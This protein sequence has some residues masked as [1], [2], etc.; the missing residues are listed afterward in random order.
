V[1]VEREVLAE[2]L[3][4]LDVDGSRFPSELRINELGE[5]RS[6]YMTILSGG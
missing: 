3:A 2:E 4:R 6:L 1:T 5:G